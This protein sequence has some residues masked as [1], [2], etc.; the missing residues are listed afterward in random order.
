[1]QIRL[2]NDISCMRLALP[3]SMLLEAD[4]TNSSPANMHDR[5]WVIG[6]HLMLLSAS[7]YMRGIDARTSG[8]RLSPKSFA[9]DK[10]RILS[11]WKPEQVAT[12]H[13]FY[14]FLLV[15]PFSNRHDAHA[16]DSIS[17]SSCRDLSRLLL[18]QFADKW[19]IGLIASSKPNLILTQT[20]H[21]VRRY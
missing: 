16:K 15:N 8:A 14:T 10:A 2:E 17:L 4:Y 11:A 7:W 1:M 13:P 19:T 3:P 12:A 20:C 18:R 5:N 9:F 6:T 21:D